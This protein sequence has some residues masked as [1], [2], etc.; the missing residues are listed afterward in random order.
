MDTLMFLQMMKECKYCHQ[1][2]SISEFR[3][4]RRKCKSCERRYGRKYAKNNSVKRR[5]YAQ[6]NAEKLRLLQSKRYQRL[7]KKINAKNRKRYADDPE[8]RKRKNIMR[9]IQNWEGGRK[10][11]PRNS[12]YLRCSYAFYKKW[13]EFNFSSG[14]TM[15]SRGVVWHP[16][17]V[18]PRNLFKLYNSEKNLDRRNLR[19]CY[20]WYNVSP[21]NSSLNL[22]KHDNIDVEQIKNHVK[23]LR[24]FESMTGEKVDEDYYELCATYLD[25]GNP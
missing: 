3:K 14:M 6:A 13:L 11:C 9:V 1:Y 2:F 17:H 20:S 19:L 8:Y 7:K 25:A 23:A 18:I 24:C 5:A 4:N 21:I 10:N 15:E 12:K 22:T 16:D